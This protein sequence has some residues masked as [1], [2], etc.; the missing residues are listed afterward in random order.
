MI[1]TST[2]LAE[3]LENLSAENLKLYSNAQIRASTP[4]HSM[5]VLAEKLIG[6][7]RVNNKSKVIV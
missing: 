2:A 6:L 3:V 5:P 4:L 1:K 7:I